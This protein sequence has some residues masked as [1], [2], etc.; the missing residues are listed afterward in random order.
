L[1]RAL[2]LVAGLML[3]GCNTSNDLNTEPTMSRVGAA[4]PL[5][6]LA[7]EQAM[8]RDPNSTYVR[9][10]EGLFRDSRAHQV[11]DVLTVLIQMND[12][13]ALDNSSERSR[14]SSAG[15]G[16]GFGF[17]LDGTGSDASLNGSANSTSKSKGEGA[18]E[19]SEAI[20]VTLAAV[21]TSVL[22]NGNLIISGSQE[23][24]V[25]FEMRVV[26]IQ[27]AHFLWWPRP[28]DRSAAAGRA[29]PDLRS[30]GSFLRTAWPSFRSQPPA[31]RHPPRPKPRCAVSRRPSVAPF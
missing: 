16:A 23:M 28:I 31:K 17:S 25:N 19:R 29:P 10:G 11:G 22:P 24:R 12:K 4:L 20:K 1:K 21:V 9:G 30:R 7:P 6:A 2:L 26:N 5:N 18:V 3:A 27:G 14:V 8:F 15:F 13:A